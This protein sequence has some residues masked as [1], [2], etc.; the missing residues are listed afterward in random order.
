MVKNR[1]TGIKEWGL[2][3]LASLCRFT[4]AK[5]LQRDFT[6]KLAYILD[7]KLEKLLSESMAIMLHQKHTT[8]SLENVI[9]V[10]PSKYKYFAPPTKRYGNK[11][12][13]EHAYFLARDPLNKD[14]K[15]RMQK[16]ANDSRLAEDAFFLIHGYI[17]DFAKILVRCCLA[18][19][20]HAKRDTLI[21]EDIDYSLIM[22]KD[23]KNDIDDD[24][25]YDVD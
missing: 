11:N 6:T 21:P 12:K 4:G 5:R 9:K 14:I 17:E 15:T 1:N 13:S 23:C 7:R 10:L 8:L 16:H 24:N 25:D 3:A 22:M 18:A 2:A 19:A 20:S